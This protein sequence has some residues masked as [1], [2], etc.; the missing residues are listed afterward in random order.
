MA[1]DPQAEWGGVRAQKALDQVRTYGEANALPCCICHQPIDYS[2][3]HP[4]KQA[5]T[6]Q[7]LKSRHTYPHLT[8]TPSNWAPAHADCNYS[9]GNRESVSLGPTSI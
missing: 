3:R 9:Q 1:Y 5:C 4:H 2:L 6:V 7:H 8:W